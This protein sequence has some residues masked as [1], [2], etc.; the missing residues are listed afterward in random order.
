MRADCFFRAFNRSVERMLSNE[1]SRCV[2]VD[3][4]ADSDL[5]TVLAAAKAAGAPVGNQWSGIHEVQTDRGIWSR[6][7]AKKLG[8]NPTRIAAASF[9]TWEQLEA[10]ELAMH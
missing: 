4:P 10:E 8:G 3:V 1:N 9:K 2:V 5:S 7:D 6:S